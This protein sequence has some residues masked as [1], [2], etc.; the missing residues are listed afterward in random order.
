MI[1]IVLHCLPN[2]IDQVYWIV[3]QLTRSSRYI[4]PKKFILDFT[5]NVSD[6][7]VDWKKSLISKEY[8]TEKFNLA[9]LRSPFINQHKISHEQTG[10]N[11]VRRNAIRCKDNTTHII[12]LDTDVIFPEWILYYMYQSITQVTNKYYIIT[13]QLFQLWDTSWDI[14]SHP[15]TRN[16]SR[17]KKQWLK[18]PYQVF[19]TEIQE[20]K[21]IPIP[22][23]KFGGGW[24]NMFNK[25]LLELIDIPDSLGHYGMDDTYIVDVANM[26]KNVNLDIQQFVLNDIIVKEDR[27]YRTKTMDPFIVSNS[28]QSTLRDNSN[29]VYSNEIQKVKEKI[30]NGTI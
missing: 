22:I 7:N 6:E 28:K 9:F 2:E 12:Y 24:F 8:C 16:V 26:L 15:N 30:S 25:Q 5:L 18:D 19:D 29:I 10:C 27:V 11:T 17:N 20:V 1:K 14:I 3:D 4:D 23:I 13:P 21:L